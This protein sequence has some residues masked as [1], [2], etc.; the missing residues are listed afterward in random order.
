MFTPCL[1]RKWAYSIA[2]IRGMINMIIS[3][4]IGNIGCGMSCS[5]GFT[6]V[7]A[8]VIGP[9]GMS[10]SDGFTGVTAVV[11]GQSGVSHL[12]LAIG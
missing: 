8:V 7:T 12:I 3:Q 10:C 2:T 4:N 6:G 5:D 1:Q 11:I 9:S